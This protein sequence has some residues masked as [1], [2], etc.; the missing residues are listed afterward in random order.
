LVRGYVAIYGLGTASDELLQ[1]ARSVSDEAGVAFHQH[2]GYTPEATSGDEARIGGSRISRLARVGVLGP[3]STLVH[4]YVLRD[5]DIAEIRESG[6]SVVWC[7]AAYLQLGINAST[8]CRT[9]ELVRQ[10]VTV[11]M[12]DLVGSLEAGKRADVVVRRADLPECMPGVNPAHQ[13][14]LTMRTG[15]V[16]T[17]LVNGREVMHSG[18]CTTVNADAVF[19]KARQSVQSRMERLGLRPQRYWSN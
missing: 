5:H 2:E 13:L 3:R 14:A 18:Q 16:D 17:V 15:T 10:G 4:M 12:A 9:P 11:G 6:T 8:P 1:A 19:M 7:P